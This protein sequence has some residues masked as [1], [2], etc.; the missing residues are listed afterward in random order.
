MVGGISPIGYGSSYQTSGV[1]GSYGFGPTGVEETSKLSG[2]KKVDARQGGECQT[3]KN[4]KYKD[5]SNEMVSFKSA[6][7]VSPGASGAAVRSHE[8]EHVSNAYNKARQTGGKVIHATVSIQTSVCPECGR[9]YVSGGTTSTAISTPINQ[10]QKNP[11]VQNRGKISNMN[12]VGLN[13]DF[14]S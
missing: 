8:G 13:M 3:C 6:A 7:H 10:D 4:R 2:D 12:G 1:E 14:K 11:Y 9:S 5:G